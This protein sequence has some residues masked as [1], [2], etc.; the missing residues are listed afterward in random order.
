M[1]RPLHQVLHEQVV[2]PLLELAQHLLHLVHRHPLLEVDR[3]PIVLPV[4]RVGE[5]WSSIG[6]V[7]EL[8]VERLS[9]HSPP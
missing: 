2:G 1:A 6:V 4:D 8:R 5:P 9:T 3:K 7:E